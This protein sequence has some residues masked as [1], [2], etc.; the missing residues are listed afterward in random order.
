MPSQPWPWRRPQRQALHTTQPPRWVCQIESNRTAILPINYL[1][2]LHVINT[3]SS[4]EQII[5]WLYVL[6]Q[7]HVQLNWCFL[8][9]DLDVHSWVSVNEC[10]AAKHV[11]ICPAWSPAALDPGDGDVFDSRCVSEQAFLWISFFIAFYHLKRQYREYLYLIGEISCE[12][13]SH[14]LTCLSRVRWG[15]RPLQSERH[16]GSSLLTGL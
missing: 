7:V 8:W 13:S 1:D 12:V 14:C 10:P 4:L 11:F 15:D 16:R 9:S 6:K 3:K 5:I 2:K